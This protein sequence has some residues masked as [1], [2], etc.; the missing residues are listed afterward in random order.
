MLTVGVVDIV[1][2]F[3]AVALIDVVSIVAVAN[4]LSFFKAENLV[5][6]VDKSDVADVAVVVA[7]VQGGPA[8][9]DV[10]TVVVVGNVGRKTTLGFVFKIEQRPKN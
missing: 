10:A 5:T 4:I 1:A 9:F 6:A 8:N 2:V 3:L 7:D